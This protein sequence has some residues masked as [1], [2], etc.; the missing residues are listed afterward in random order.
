VRVIV[1]QRLFWIS[2]PRRLRKY[3]HEHRT[4]LFWRSWKNRCKN[5]DVKPMTGEPI[6][7][8]W[9]FCLAPSAINLK[10]FYLY[11]WSSWGDSDT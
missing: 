4:L 8:K 6:Y 11:T 2:L 10:P 7:N 5:L 3:L 9:I 1:P